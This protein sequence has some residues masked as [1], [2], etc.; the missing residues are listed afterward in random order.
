VRLCRKSSTISHTLSQERDDRDRRIT[1]CL[2]AVLRQA[3]HERE[4]HP[5]LGTDSVHPELVEGW[6]ADFSTAS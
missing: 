3:Q 4:N 5:D 1:R 2:Y 6:T